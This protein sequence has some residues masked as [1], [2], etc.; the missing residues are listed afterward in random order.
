MADRHRGLAGHA[1]PETVLVAEAYLGYG[2]ELSAGLTSD[3]DK[4]LIDR[5]RRPG[6]G[7]VRVTCARSWPT[8]RGSSASGEPRTS[9]HRGVLPGR[10]RRP[11]RW[12]RTLRGA[13]WHEGQ[14]AGRRMAPAYSCSRRRRNSPIPP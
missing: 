11:R 6:R 12:P 2:M 13:L 9:S 8:S 10:R 1:R 7:G 14:F 4:R 3:Y 5:I